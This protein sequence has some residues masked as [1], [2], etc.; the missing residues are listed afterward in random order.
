[1]ADP[2]DKPADKP[3]DNTERVRVAVEEALAPLAIELVDVEMVGSGRART[4]RLRVD[5]EGGIDLDAITRA[6]H[7]VSPVLDELDPIPGPYALE[8][9]SPGVERPLRRPDHFR[10][11]VGETISVKT[12]VEVD[13]ARR[14]RGPL[15]DVHDEGFVIEVDG[16]PRRVR[17]DEVAQARTVFEWAPPARPV[18]SRKK[19]SKKTKTRTG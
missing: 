2:A 6:T 17:F 16:T 10:R 13:G 19:A 8:V 14:H 4:L 15:T 18:P 7:V 3:A 12:H 9:S 11:V 5:R 1:M